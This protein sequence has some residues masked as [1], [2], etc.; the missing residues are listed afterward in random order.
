MKYAMCFF[1]LVGFVIGIVVGTW[2][3]ISKLLGVGNILFAGIATIIPIIITGGIHIDGFCDTVDARSSHQNT[4]R[5]LEILKDPHIGAFALI[6]CVIYFIAIFSFWTEINI[7]IETIIFISLGFMLSR[8]LSALAIVTFK[9]SKNSG[10]AYM[11]SNSSQK[12]IVKKSMFIYIV[13]ISTIMI[14]INY[15]L[16]IT[17]IILAI[18]C[19]VKYKKMSYNEFKGIT[20]DLAGYFLVMLELILLIAMVIL[21][22]AP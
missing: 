20:G 2:M 16:A 12:E 21:G 5:K 11:F 9:C 4:E 15:K 17:T 14:F 3:Y 22:G 6:Y 1:P 7:N 8:A 13:I 19:F 18:L 10:L